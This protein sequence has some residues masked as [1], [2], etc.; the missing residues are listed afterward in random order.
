MKGRSRGLCI[1]WEI[2][3]GDRSRDAMA[4]ERGS[5]EGHS[6]VLDHGAAQPP[7]QTQ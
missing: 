6:G 2:S 1:I 7:E 4:Q 5:G 3:L